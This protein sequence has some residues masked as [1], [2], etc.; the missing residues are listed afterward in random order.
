MGLFPNS[1]SVLIDNYFCMALHPSVLTIPPG[2]LHSACHPIGGLRHWAF[3]QVCHSPEIC[4]GDSGADD[5]AAVLRFQ[6][7][8]DGAAAF[9]ITSPTFLGGLRIIDIVLG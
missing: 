5:R 3:P 1:S 7:R 6:Q 9:L 4:A 2:K 8:K